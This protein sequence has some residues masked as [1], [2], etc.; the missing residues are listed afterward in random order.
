MVYARE[1]SQLNNRNLTIVLMAK[2]PYDIPRHRTAAV[3]TVG[4]SS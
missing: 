3:L 1:V 4:S 2:G